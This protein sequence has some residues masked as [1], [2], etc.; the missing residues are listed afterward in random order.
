MGADVSAQLLPQLF[1]RPAELDLDQFVM[2]HG[3]FDFP[4]DG[5]A[6]PGRPEHDNGVQVMGLGAEKAFLF[7]CERGMGRFHLLASGWSV[8]VILFKVA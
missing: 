8:K 5:R 2:G 7:R 1:V 3:L 4:H 6:Q